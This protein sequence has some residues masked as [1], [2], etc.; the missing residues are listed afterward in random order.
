ML[1]T[2]LAAAAL[3]SLNLAGT[4]AQAAPALE[5][6]PDALK[7]LLMTINER[8]EIADLVALTKWDSAKPIQ[9]SE[10]ESKVIA[11]A[12]KQ[13]V[14]YSIPRNEATQ[15]MAAQIEA[16]KLVQYRLLAE[17]HAAG[18][19]PEVKRPDLKSLIRPRLDLLQTSLLQNYVRFIPYRAN[20]ACPSWLNQILPQLAKDELHEMALIRATGE[21]C[22]PRSPGTS[23]EQP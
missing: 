5:P 7:P 2:V 1:K 4:C 16:N 18:N 14:D 23:T 12:Q 8:L 3:L 13:A 6:S 17:W 10:R 21:L 15:L 22:I 9:D 19:A 20:P 11:D